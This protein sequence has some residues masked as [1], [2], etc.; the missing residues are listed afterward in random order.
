MGVDEAAG[1]ARQISRFESRCRS[2]GNELSNS[3]NHAVPLIVSKE[4]YLVLLDRAAERASELVLVVR[5][6]LSDV[7]KR[8]SPF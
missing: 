1:D 3:L 8:Q 6:A 2:S 4:K 5:A 7:Y